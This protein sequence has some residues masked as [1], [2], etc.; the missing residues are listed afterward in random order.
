[1]RRRRGDQEEPD[2]EVYKKKVDYTYSMQKFQK[3]QQCLVIVIWVIKR[4]E[5]GMHLKIQYYF[6]FFKL[7]PC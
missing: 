7:M 3:K 5:D 1:M 4:I 6:I 2:G